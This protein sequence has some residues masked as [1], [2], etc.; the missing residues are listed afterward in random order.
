MD[1]LNVGA[2]IIPMYENSK[3]IIWN[4]LCLIIML[5]VYF[6]KRHCSH[7]QLLL[8]LNSQASAWSAVSPRALRSTGQM[9]LVAPRA[10]FKPRGD[11]AFQAV[12]PRLWN[13][14]PL[15]L[16]FNESINFFNKQLKTFLYRKAFNLLNWWL[17]VYWIL[18]ILFCFICEALCDFYLWKVLYK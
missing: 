18:F 17:T 4:Q 14:L 13:S 6:A 16:H 11:R 15:S 7:F 8:V 12:A 5:F 1:V 2:V 3:L 9:L 10:Q